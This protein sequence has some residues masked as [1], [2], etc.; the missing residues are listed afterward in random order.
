MA[1]IDVTSV[2]AQVGMQF[3]PILAVGGAALL[4]FVALKSF[5][6]VK[7][8]LG[9]VGESN[10]VQARAR[11]EARL[12]ARTKFEQ[13]HEVQTVNYV[14]ADEYRRDYGDWELDHALASAERFER[15]FESGTKFEQIAFEAMEPSGQGR[16]QALV[17]RGMGFGDAVRAVEMRDEAVERAEAQRVLDKENRKGQ[18]FA[19][20]GISAQQLDDFE[21]SYRDMW[22]DQSGGRV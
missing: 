18:E 2:V 22:A 6:W 19:N 1:A 16:V 9:A 3:P 5:V 21:A 11:A 4:V 10:E 14:S 13:S 8:S 15:A 20:A 12:T 7:L 17:D